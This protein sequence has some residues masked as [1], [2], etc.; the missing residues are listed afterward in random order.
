MM[1]RPVLNEEPDIIGSRDLRISARSFLTSMG[2]IDIRK[3]KKTLDTPPG[4][5]FYTNIFAA[6]CPILSEP[7]Q[8]SVT[9][10][11]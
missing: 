5:F 10:R 6:H 4:P 2:R 1:T 3:R 9:A 11:E 7:V 8:E